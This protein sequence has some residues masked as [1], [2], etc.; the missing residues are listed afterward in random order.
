MSVSYRRV[1]QRFNAPETDKAG[2]DPALLDLAIDMDTKHEAF[3]L[4][5]KNPLAQRI[6]A[7][8]GNLVFTLA[9]I[10]AEEANGFPNASDPADKTIDAAEAREAAVQA[11][12]AQLRK[13]GIAIDD[14]TGKVD[15]LYQGI[16][17]TAKAMA[18]EI[19]R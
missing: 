1:A 11:A 4:Y 10:A 6:S 13:N 5:E 2:I 3:S 16:L 17:R 15:I 12:T 8:S 18:T 19:E 7:G 9:H 14:I